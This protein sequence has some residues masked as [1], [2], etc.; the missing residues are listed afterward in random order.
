MKATKVLYKNGVV[1]SNVCDTEN[2]LRGYAGQEGPKAIVAWVEG[3]FTGEVK[4][5]VSK[6]GTTWHTLTDP[7]LGDISLDAAGYQAIS[8]FAGK[9][10]ADVSGVT[11]M[12]TLSITITR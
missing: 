5:E 8:N 11:V 10:R 3:T 4:F 1:V 6:D 9:I 7:N 12:G 2:D